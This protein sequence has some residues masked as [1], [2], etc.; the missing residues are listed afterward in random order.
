MDAN[1]VARAVQQ[2]YS[3]VC[4][5]CRKL[6]RGKDAG[7]DGCLAKCTGPIGGD[8]FPEYDGDM[9][10]MVRWCFVCGCDSD[11]ALQVGQK[12]RRVG[13]CKVHLTHLHELVPADGIVPDGQLYAVRN[14]GMVRVERIL[15]K[16]ATLA[17]E[18]V[19]QELAWAEEDRKLSEELGLD[20][21]SPVGN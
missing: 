11:Y 5:T 12:P 17:Q 1:N 6:W 15:R 4:A 19:K 13:V 8:T 3:I 16:P 10:D 2:G 21:D 18:I 20:P 9:P 7:F 14:G